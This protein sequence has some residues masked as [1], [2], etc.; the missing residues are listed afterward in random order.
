MTVG[1]DAPTFPLKQRVRIRKTE[2]KKE[3]KKEREVFDKNFLWVKKACN[4]SYLIIKGVETITMCRASQ[5]QENASAP[6]LVPRETGLSVTERVWFSWDGE[7]D[8]V[9]LPEK[10]TLMTHQLSLGW[11]WQLFPPPNGLLSVI[12]T[13][14]KKKTMFNFI[15]WKMFCIKTDIKV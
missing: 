4:T 15:W 13:T 1:G 11:C 8:Y 12:S 14:M 2:R 6:V 3:K 9:T 7:F 10:K 5:S